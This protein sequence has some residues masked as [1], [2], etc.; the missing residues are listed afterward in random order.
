MTRN[1]KKYFQPSLS[2]E[3]SDV[4]TIFFVQVSANDRTGFDLFTGQI[5]SDV[6]DSERHNDVTDDDAN[7]DDE[8]N[9]RWDYR[10]VGSFWVYLIGTYVFIYGLRDLSSKYATKISEY[11]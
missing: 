1:G 11:V 9:P 8:D 6:T 5:R 10:R 4:K 2:N 3:S 7:D